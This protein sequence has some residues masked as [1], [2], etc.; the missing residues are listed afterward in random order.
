DGV[1]PFS[2]GQKLYEMARGPKRRL[3]VE[4][5]GHNDL[6]WVADQEYWHALWD[7]ATSLPRTDDVKERR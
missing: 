6:G 7:F 2:H 4:G 5:A 1:V 3:W